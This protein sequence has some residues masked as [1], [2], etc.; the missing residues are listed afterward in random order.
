VTVTLE[1]FAQLLSDSGLMSAEEA[2]TLRAKLA[3]DPPVQTAGY[4]C[5]MAHFFV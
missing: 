1:Q 2:G 4:R 3:A 5:G